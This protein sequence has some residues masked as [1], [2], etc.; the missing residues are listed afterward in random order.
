MIRIILAAITTAFIVSPASAKPVPAEALAKVPNIQSVSMSVD[1]KQLV[2]LVALPGSDNQETALATWD[3]DH[4]DEGPQV[5]PS[6]DRMKFI[7]ASALKSDRLLVIGRQEW[8]GRLGGCGEG[9]FSGA[10]HTFVSKAYLTDAKHSE[11]EEAFANNVRKLGVSKATQRCLEIGG[12]ASL[13]NAL[14][15][16]PH[17]VIIRQINGLALQG[18]YY[19]YDLRNGETELLVRASAG[20]NPGLFHPRTGEVLTR[21]E[22]DGDSD[23]YTQ[24]ILILNR[25]SGEFER[26]DKLSTD[27][28]NRHS[29]DLVGIDED[30]GKYYVLTDLF[31]NQVQAWMYDPAKREFDEEPLL[32]H[33]QYSINSLVFGNQP[34]N[35]NQVIGFR[36]AGPSVQTQYVDP[37][38]RAIHQG[39]KQAFPG[40]NISINGYNDDLSTVLFTTSSHKHPPA[41]HLLH[42]RQQVQSL[43]SQRP[44]FDSDEVGEQRW[45]TYEARDGMEIPGILDLPVDWEEGD[46]PLPTVIHPH[47]GPWS[48]DTTGWDASGWVPFLTSRGF[49]VL[50]PQYRGSAG[51]GRDLWLAGDREWGQKMQ[52]DKDDGAQWLVEQGIADPDKLVIFGYSYGGFAAVAATVRENSPYQCAIA[53]APVADLGRLGTTW[54]ENRLQR[55]LQGQTV[56]GMDPMRN[57][58]KAN[59]PILLYVGNRDVRTPAFHAENFYKAVQEH[60]PARFKLIDDMPHSMPWYPRHQTETL[61]LIENFLNSVCLAD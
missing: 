40:Q 13:V 43:G 55:V 24:R 51:L 35:F 59:I 10:T 6:G 8:T 39:L 57:T 19:R 34:S 44:W 41:Y 20:S 30:S 32:S 12:E 18:N 7:A 1:G 28:A 11:F 49:A 23:G 56:T 16:D 38:F 21:T 29:V 53:G 17:K 52:D 14:P 45:V 54:S 47:G 3:L 36:L 58:E 50:R 9:N 31:S 60:V 46:D 37:D 5:T 61:E 25:E 27:L 33:D 26:H 4:M 42:D 22:I 48:R 15:L 2:A